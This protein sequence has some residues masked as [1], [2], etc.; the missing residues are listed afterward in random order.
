M[1]TFVVITFMG[2]ER[3]GII[4]DLATVVREH[5]ANWEGSRSTS[6][7]GRFAGVLQVRV[8]EAQQHALIAGLRAIEGLTIV[9][10]QGAADPAPTDVLTLDVTGADRPGLVRG[11]ADALHR[12]GGN[13]EDLDTRAEEAPMAGGMVFRAVVRVALPPGV[14]KADVREALEPIGDDLLIEIRRSTDS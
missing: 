13:I 12:L 8:A 5:G 10:E 6:L 9:V 3:A 4:R 14:G 7:A 1:H 2:P 11:I